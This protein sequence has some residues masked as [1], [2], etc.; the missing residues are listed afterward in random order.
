MAKLDNGDELKS[1]HIIASRQICMCE[2]S[3][4]LKT[5]EGQ[6]SDSDI[7]SSCGKTN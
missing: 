7:L 6:V 3:G 5:V 1:F 2:I 4:F